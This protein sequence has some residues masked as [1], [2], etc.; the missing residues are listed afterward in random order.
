[1]INV[2][3]KRILN[4]TLMLY[5]R[6]GVTMLVALIT[7]R[8]VLK[9]LG[10]S[11]FGLYNVTGGLIF[12]F[13]FL[14]TAT[15]GATQRYL[16]VAL[17]QKNEKRCADIVSA[18]IMIQLT[19][20]IVLIIC[21]EVIGVYLINKVLNIPPGRMLAANCVFQFSIFTMLINMVTSPYRAMV[22]ALEKMAILAWFSIIEVTMRLALIA[23]LYF[24]TADRLILYGLIYLACSALM[25]G[26]Y[27]RYCRHLNAEMASFHLVRDKE[28][29]KGLLSFSGWSLFGGLA[30]VG[31]FQGLDIVVNIFS[32]VVANAAMGIAN[33]VI[34][35]MWQLIGGFQTAYVP[36]LTKLY[37]VGRYDELMKLSFRASKLTFLLVLLLSLP[38][39]VNTEYILQL[40]LGQVP[41]YSVIFVRLY[42]LYRLIESLFTPFVPL[43]NAT[44]DIKVYQLVS[45]ALIL[46]VLPLSALALYCGAAVWS[47]LVIKIILVVLVC[48]WRVAF[49]GK[50]VNMPRRH[51]A[52]KVLLPA[53][54]T[55]MICFGSVVPLS[56]YFNGVKLL[57]LSVPISFLM[58][59]VVGSTILLNREERKACLS[60]LK[61]RLGI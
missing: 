33:Q 53:M 15:T 30:T 21:A 41:E 19:V 54:L 51:Y 22:I 3:N 4:N 17:G 11:D 48:L 36:H 6:T 2:D 1:M 52:A 35:A 32:G 44:G 24:C 60:L 5:F 25:F 38:L 61:E 37:A 9:L 39:I 40:W 55:T 59:A 56:R 27:A 7:S 29:F 18:A 10:V 31:S 13:G 12:L 42:V 34:N 16:N 8:V 23:L 50:R 45:S 57:M 20:G 46:M 14:M 28:L 47:V 58:A 43:I 26:L 49:V